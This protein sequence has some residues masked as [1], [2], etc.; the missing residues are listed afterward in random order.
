MPNETLR[1]A[2]T[3]ANAQTISVP[4]SIA[5]NG[6]GT[7]SFTLTGVNAGISTIQAFFD[8]QG[9]ASNVGGAIWQQTNGPIAIRGTQSVS[10]WTGA[11]GGS[12]VFP[13]GLTVSQLGSAGTYTSLMFN[14]SPNGLFPGDP[15]ETGNTA[16]PFV[17]NAIT[18]G[19][20][21][22]GDVV[23]SGANGDFNMILQCEV[24]VAQAGQISFSAYVNSE[25]VIGF[26]ANTQDQATLPSYVSGDGQNFAGVSSSEYPSLAGNNGGPF[27]NQ[28]GWAQHNFVVNF[29][30]AGI[31]GMQVCMAGGIVHERQFALMANGRVIPT[32]AN[33]DS[34]LP[35]LT[36]ASG[37]FTLIAQ[38]DLTEFIAGQTGTFNISLSG[39]KLTQTQAVPLYPGTTGQLYIS[40]QSGAPANFNF[41]TLPSGGG[42]DRNA[43][44]S[45]FSLNGSSNSSW[46]NR[47][48][49]VATATGYQL[50]YNG[51]APDAN[52]PSTT[53][54][55][56]YDE[57]AMFNPATGQFDTYT[58]STQG[59]GSSASVQVDWLVKPFVS[60][61]NYGN[62]AADGGTYSMTVT[63]NQPL[64]PVQAGVNAVFSGTPA[65]RVVSS[66]PNFNG[67]GFLVGWTLTLTT[68]PGQSGAVAFISLTAT[69]TIT[70]LSGD[71]FV[72]QAVTYINQQ[73][74]SGIFL[75]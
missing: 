51:A 73:I 5:A 60:N 48:S 70:F 19:G 62:I 8:Q 37:N 58:P 63:L 22:A 50:F 2:V 6:S 56:T 10:A 71:S 34:S 65:L 16:N 40:D 25:F 55:V 39:V 29:P 57:L 36:A 46:Q 15:H 43:A 26:S 9:L 44:V 59:G 38:G 30:K 45:L 52:I 14:T 20:A 28:G 1:I 12:G 53:V 17:N 41:P 66:S 47:L 61:V 72:T 49:I 33:N 11:A 31:Y 68:T 35:P 23:V 13:A 4:I 32:V 3:G 7:A 67:A 64:P 27:I 21:Y 69:D 54:Q 75:S 24:V 74:A 42:V 18:T